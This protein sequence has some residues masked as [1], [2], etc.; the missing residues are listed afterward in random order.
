METFVT[1]VNGC[2]AFVTES[3]VSN[4]AGFQDHDHDQAADMTFY[5]YFTRFGLVQKWL[6]HTRWNG[7]CVIYLT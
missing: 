5:H 1:I 2:F 3:C 4:V 6:W 7:G